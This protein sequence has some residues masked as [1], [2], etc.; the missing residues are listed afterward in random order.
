MFRKKIDLP[1][2]IRKKVTL[3]FFEIRADFYTIKT[4]V[5]FTT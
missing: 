4:R 1:D 2:T 5:H 3:N